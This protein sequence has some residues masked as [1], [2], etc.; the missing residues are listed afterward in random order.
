MVL[1]IGSCPQG[2]GAQS[3]H[4]LIQFFSPPSCP[5]S[6][7]DRKTRLDLAGKAIVWG[8]SVTSVVD[9]FLPVS[10][11]G[12]PWHPYIELGHLST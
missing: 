11:Q 8:A 5:Q 10:I 9:L 4:M 3:P 2:L 12:S 1:L 7:W 6:Q